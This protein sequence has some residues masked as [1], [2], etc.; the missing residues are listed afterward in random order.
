MNNN[1]ILV[2]SSRKLIKKG[3]IGYGWKNVNFK[4]Y[5]SVKDLFDEGFKGISIGRKRKQIKRFFTLTTGDLVVVPVSGAIAVG[6]VEGAKEYEPN[7]EIPLSANRIKVNF[8]KKDNGDILYVPRVEIATNLERRLKIRASIAN[9]EGFSDEIEKIALKLDKNEMYTWDSDMQQKE[10]DAKENF[11]KKLEQRLTTEEGMG[12]SSGGYGL[13]LLIQEIFQ[14]KGYGA[15]IPSKNSRPAGE[16]VDIVAVKEGE[17][18]AK[19]EKYLIQAKHH[20][21]ITGR[22]GL[23][24]LIACKDDED[25]NEYT[26]KKILMTTAKVSDNLKDEAKKE[27]IVIV[28]GEDLARWIYENL[29]LLSKRTLRQLGISEV[30][31]LI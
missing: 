18:D 3:L 8:Y 16:D 30:P 9:L 10:E 14:A 11:I 21:G 5:S 29:E 1:I 13:E 31:F 24:Q 20:R 26:Y 22:V 12:L 4:N 2:R 19:G 17:F 23:D 25:D 6:I 7:D 28:E 15:S 27:E